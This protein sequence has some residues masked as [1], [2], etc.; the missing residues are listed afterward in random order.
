MMSTVLQDS[1]SNSSGTFLILCLLPSITL[2]LLTQLVSD[3]SSIRIETE[4]LP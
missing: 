3:M 2:S 4:N 1:R